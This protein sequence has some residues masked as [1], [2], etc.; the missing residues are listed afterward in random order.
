MRIG[1]EHVHQE[2][3]D[4]EKRD[5]K[6]DFQAAHGLGSFLFLPLKENHHVREVSFQLWKKV[7]G[8]SR[9]DI[10]S[11]GLLFIDVCADGD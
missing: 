11:I 2:H 10:S 7:P 5:G 6:P 4:E 1:T 9:Q 8:K 3:K